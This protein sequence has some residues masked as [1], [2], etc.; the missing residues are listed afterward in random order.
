MHN[1]GV[2]YMRDNVVTGICIFAITLA[3]CLIVSLSLKGMYGDE[4]NISFVKDIFSIGAT[5]FTGAIAIY[6][7][8]GWKEQHKATIHKEQIYKA[9]E[10]LS[11]L[12]TNLYQ[13]RNIINKI[14]KIISSKSY[15]YEPNLIKIKSKKLDDLLFD[16][17]THINNYQI[18]KKTN[19]L[20]T[21]YFDFE[22]LYLQIPLILDTLID[23]YK[24]YCNVLQDNINEINLNKENVFQIEKKYQD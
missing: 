8:N 6:L 15:I 9:L 2:N 23:K 17:H 19:K 22:K 3:C 24:N 18:L 12:L 7:F 13:V 16:I 14:E 4:I 10:N 20:D 5:V 21:Y 1:I 11:A